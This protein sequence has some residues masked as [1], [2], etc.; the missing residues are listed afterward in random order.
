MITMKL[1]PIPITLVECLNS[2]PKFCFEINLSGTKGSQVENAEFI[3]TSLFLL[4]IS[5][6]RF[7][8]LEPKNLTKQSPYLTTLPKE[9]I[10]SKSK[11]V[12]SMLRLHVSLWRTWITTMKNR[13]I[14]TII[15]LLDSKMEK[16]IITFWTK[17][18][19]NSWIRF[20]S[21]SVQSWALI[22]TWQQTYS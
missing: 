14:K 7:T 4:L 13:R 1:I 17:E 10:R 5:S 12:T 6:W 8:I 15:S 20:Q 11:S 3:F 16:S 19:S 22:M 18:S 21:G 9:R 2:L